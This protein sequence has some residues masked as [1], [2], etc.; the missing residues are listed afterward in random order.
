MLVPWHKGI[1]FEINF[2][3][4]PSPFRNAFDLRPKK[5]KPFFQKTSPT[6]QPSSSVARG[7]DGRQVQEAV[8]DAEGAGDRFLHAGVE[9]AGQRCQ[10]HSEVLQG[11][12]EVRAGY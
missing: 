8:P 7:A 3:T 5:G 12:Q 10:D 2:Q 9:E 6:S 1:D 4:G 11:D